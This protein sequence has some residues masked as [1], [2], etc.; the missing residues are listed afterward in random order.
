MSQKHAQK[1]YAMGLVEGE[2]VNVFLRKKG[3]R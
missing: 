2:K 3:N 1:G